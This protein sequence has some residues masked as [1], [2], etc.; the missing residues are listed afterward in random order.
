MVVVALAALAISTVTLPQLSSDE[1][2]LMGTFSFAFLGVLFAQ[3]GIAGISCSRSRSAIQALL[4]VLS[5]LMALSMFVALAILGLIIPEGA[6]M[7]SVAVLVLV[8]Y[9]TTWV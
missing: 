5:C 9:L 2:W 3:W 6:A 4:G 1:K 8:I 7:L